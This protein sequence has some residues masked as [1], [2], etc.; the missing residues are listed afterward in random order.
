MPTFQ[1]FV[2]QVLILIISKKYFT[3]LFT[4]F[5]LFTKVG[6]VLRL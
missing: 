2:N 3:E 5:K 4:V 6:E 1:Y